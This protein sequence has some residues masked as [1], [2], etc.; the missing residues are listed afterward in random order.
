M[1]KSGKN[2][3]ATVAPQS[4]D[5]LFNLIQN[6]NTAEK[7]YFKK[8]SGIHGGSPGN[9]YLRLFDCYCRMKAYDGQA[10]RK[11]FEGEKILNQLGVAK[12]YLHESILNALLNYHKG[13][14]VTAQLNH[15]LALSE[16]A[17]QKSDFNKC[18]N[19]IEKG[20]QLALQHEKYA[21]LICFYN[22]EIILNTKLGYGAGE[23]EKL[24]EA[25]LHA[26][27]VSDLVNEINLYSNRVIAIF[28]KCNYKPGQ[29][30]RVKTDKL[31]AEIW[32]NESGYRQSF[33]ATLKYFEICRNYEFFVL[34]NHQTA[35]QLSE[36]S[37]AL[38]EKHPEKI[39]VY[40]WNY[41]ATLLGNSEFYQNWGKFTELLEATCKTEQALY[42]HRKTLG[43]PSY[44]ILLAGFSR[45]RLAALLFSG[46]YE[47]AVSHIKKYE[48]LFTE[49]SSARAADGRVF[50]FYKASVLLFVDQPDAALML[51]Q[52]LTLHVDKEIN[53]QMKFLIGLTEIMAHYQVDN[54]ALLPHLLMS[55]QRW[56]KTHYNNM[57][58]GYFIFAAMFRS[59]ARQGNNKAERRKVLLNYKKKFLYY[60]SQ[61]KKGNSLLERYIDICAWID[62]QLNKT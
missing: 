43:E 8:F 6:M 40:P 32:A 18:S 36:K 33:I 27:N 46:Q 10:I 41:I 16:I 47:E 25:R 62:I 1:K 51:L 5:E 4:N 50:M 42:L 31:M 13:N 61:L 15:L 57:S 39:A 11:E 44:E 22:N 34:E 24:Y 3:L 2:H 30:D 60:F 55:L 28:S 23:L 21:Y 48:P 53:K 35:Q 54:L 26:A 19:L 9:K 17:F 52:H 58:D 20:R 37:I 29:E 49:A 38:F 45:V 59:L 14:T 12:H 56:C 7:G